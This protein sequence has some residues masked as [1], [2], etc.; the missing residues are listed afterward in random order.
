MYDSNGNYVIK[1]EDELGYVILIDYDEMGKKI[2]E[3]DVKGEKIIYM[4]DQVD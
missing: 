4:Y 1:E 2:V 3:M